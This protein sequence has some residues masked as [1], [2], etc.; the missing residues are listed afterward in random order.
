MT[1]DLD[2]GDF[3][4]ALALLSDRSY[5]EEGIPM[6]VVLENKS[7]VVAG[8]DLSIGYLGPLLCEAAKDVGPHKS[9]HAALDVARLIEWIADRTFGPAALVQTDDEAHDE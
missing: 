8:M 4:A 7:G 2:L 1:D 5:G 9:K 6:I 3:Q